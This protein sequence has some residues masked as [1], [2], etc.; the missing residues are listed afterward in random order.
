MK[1]SLKIEQHAQSKAQRLLAQAHALGLLLKASVVRRRFRCGKPNC[2]CAHGKRHQDLIVCRLVRDKT[3]TIRVR[4]GREPEA[5]Q[6]Q[7]N[8]KKF[9]R[10]VEQLTT[11]EIRILS[12]PKG[13]ANEKHRKRG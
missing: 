5:L 7:K 3:Q 10:L 6:W 12:L 4:T 2:H 11:E 1:R 9:N 13:K 8:W